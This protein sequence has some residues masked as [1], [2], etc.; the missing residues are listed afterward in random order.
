MGTQTLKGKHKFKHLELVP[1]GQVVNLGDIKPPTTDYFID[2]TNGDDGNSG[3]AWGTGYALDTIQEAMDKM[4]ALAT[5]GRVRIFVAPGGYT[6]NITTPT[7]TNGPFG[8]LIGVSPTRLSVGAAYLGATT[9]TDPVVT[10][11]ARGWSIDGFEVDAPATDGCIY[12]SGS[13]AKFLEIANC[14]LCGSTYAT[15]F[16]VDTDDPNPLTVIRDSYIYQH[17]NV[18]LTSSNVYCL[19]WEV[20][21]CIFW[22]NGNHIAPKNSK[23]WQASVIH[24][25]VFH[26]WKAAYETTI[27]IDMRGGAGNCIGPNNF[28]GG[29]YSNAGGYYACATDEWRGNHSSASEN[30]SA[31]AN[32]A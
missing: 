28:L 27:K 8:S 6:E 13:G 1:G 16:A 26:K 32:P 31:Q 2:S 3:L 7:N 10:V 9:A 4:T 22:N 5:R 14:L 24:D 29:A 18:G 30:G 11:R 17:T 21:R 19:Q 15:G 12:L 23:G 25:S 20:A